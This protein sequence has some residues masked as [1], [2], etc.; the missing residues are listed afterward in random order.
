MKKILF[1]LLYLFSSAA[2]ASHIVGGEFELLYLKKNIYR[3]NLIYYFDEHSDQFDEPPQVSEPTILIAIFSKRTN[4]LVQKVSLKY[5]TTEDVSYF[6]PECSTGQILTDK[7]IYSEVITLSDQQFSDPE[8]YYVVWERCCRNY[9]ITNIFSDPPGN[10]ANNPKS[11]GQTFYLEFPAVTKN[12]QPFINSSPRLFPPLN[13][14]ACTFQ[15]YFANFAGTDDDGDSLVYTLVTPLK[16]HSTVPVPAIDDASSPFPEVVWKTGYGLNSI[17]NGNPDLKIS[18]DGILRVT[19][20]KAGLFVFAVRCEEYR[21]GEKIGELRRDFQLFVVGGCLPNEAPTVTGRPLTSPT[22]TKPLNVSFENDVTDE[23]RCIEVKVTDP[24][25]FSEPNHFT[26]N[27][28]IMAIPINFKGNVGKILPAQKSAWLTQSNPD[29]TFQICFDECPL[30]PDG[31]FKIGIIALDD[32]CALPLLDTLLVDVYVEPPFNT[33]P[34]F[35]TADVV[36]SLHEK[37]QQS[38]D[39]IGVDGELDPLEVTVITDGFAIEDYGISIETIKLEN[40]RYE[41]RLDWDPDCAT[42]DFSDREDFEVKVV[43]ND[44]ECNLNKPD[45]MTFNLHVELDPNT[46][47]DLEIT[48]GTDKIVLEDNHF[49]SIVHDQVVLNLTARD[50]D[51]PPQNSIVI[52]LIGVTGTQQP[53]GYQFTPVNGN[54]EI[55]TTFTW[56]PGCEIFVNSVYENEYTFTFRTVDYSCVQEKGDTIEVTMKIKDIESDH[57]KFMPP[58]LITPNGDGLNDYFG[59]DEIVKMSDSDVLPNLPADNCAGQFLSIEIFNRWGKK[60]FESDRR[61]FRWYANN[62]SAGIYFYT[63]QFTNAEYK[64]SLNVKF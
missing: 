29:I 3:L 6:Q 37:S 23:N 52:D 27:V 1:L 61:N 26:E 53:Q 56:T 28:R 35:E 47:P 41:A 16:T 5:L 20:T 11:A 63:V 30:V 19:P 45:T 34:Y 60:V 49:T 57:E 32:A 48:S 7:L 4:Q 31:H 2:M 46:A 50:S 18:R 36:Q 33:D 38:W 43:L 17:V 25:I 14:Y 62:T 15:P 22:F 9:T 44:V 59:L 54:A 58:N 55:S 24:D 13:D 51:D 21:N 8:G 40:G 10:N 64:G 42:M 39:I 12:G